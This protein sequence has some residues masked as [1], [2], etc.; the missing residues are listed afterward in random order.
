TKD[1]K[2]SLKAPSAGVFLG[3]GPST[4]TITIA[5]DGHPGSVETAFHPPPY[6]GALTMLGGG[7]Q[8]L[9]TGLSG[10]INPATGE[11]T[12]VLRLNPDGSIDTTFK[13]SIPSVPIL[14]LG[15]VPQPVPALAAQPDGKILLGSYDPFT[16]NGSLQGGVARINPDGTLDPDF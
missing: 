13:L 15:D 16:I 7:G 5:D 12:S 9:V 8:I 11:H 3:I 4:E 1:F 10:A 14:W 2:I 6:G